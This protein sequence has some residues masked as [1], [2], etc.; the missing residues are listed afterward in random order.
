MIDEVLE[1]SDFSSE[2]INFT[3]SLNRVKSKDERPKSKALH[4]LQMENKQKIE[5]SSTKIYC[6]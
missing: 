6:E 3:K 4:K 1:D 2:F 5:E